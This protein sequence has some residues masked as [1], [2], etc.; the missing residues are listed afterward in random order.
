[1]LYR[2]QLKPVHIYRKLKKNSMCTFKCPVIIN[3][4]IIDRANVESG[5]MVTDA[6]VEG[7]VL[8]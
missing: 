8:S 7:G 4:T 1:M 6:Q 5:G 2:I 3:A